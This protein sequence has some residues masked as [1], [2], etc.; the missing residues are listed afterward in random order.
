MK[1]ILP[2]LI[3]HIAIILAVIIAFGVMSVVRKTYAGGAEK[4]TGELERNVTLHILE[5]NTAKRK[6]KPQPTLLDL[7]NPSQKKSRLE[8]IIEEEL[9]RGSSFQ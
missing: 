3:A 6:E 8:Q 4:F 5:N 2:A 7:A 9:K 1:K